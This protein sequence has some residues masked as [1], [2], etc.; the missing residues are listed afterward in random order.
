[1]LFSAERGF[2]LR[3]NVQDERVDLISGPVACE[4]DMLPTDLPRLVYIKVMN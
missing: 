2:F 4:A 3:N 1:M